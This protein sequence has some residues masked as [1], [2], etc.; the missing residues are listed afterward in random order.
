MCAPIHKRNPKARIA[1]IVGNFSLAAGLILWNFT[2]HG[3]GSQP[4]F[5][6]LYGL[7]IGISIGANLSAIRCARRCRASSL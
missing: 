3:S 1:M 5:H 2:R 7:L 4:W 6:A